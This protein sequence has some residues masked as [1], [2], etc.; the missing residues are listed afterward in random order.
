MKQKI[1]FIC[2]GQLGDLLILTTAL[3]GMK[4]AFPDSELSVM[5]V[6]R[7]FYFESETTPQKLINTNCEKGT[8]LVL[9][10]NP[11]VDKVFEVNRT[12]LRK[13]KGLARLQAEWRIIKYLQQ[14]KY[15]VVICTFPEDRFALWAYLTRA[16][17]RVG[18]KKQGLSW[19][20]NNKPDISKEENGVLNYYCDLTFA[21][22]GKCNSDK[23]EYYISEKSTKWAE[24]FLINKNI[25]KSEKIICIH[26]GASGNYKIWPPEKFAEVYDNLMSRD[27]YTALLCGTNFDDQVTTEIK[28][29]IKTKLIS[30]DFSDSIDRFAA[31]LK[32]SS[33]CISN[34]SGP[35]HLAVAVGTPAISIMSRMKH[36]AW[37]IYN[38]EKNI[39]LQAENQCDSCPDNDCREIIPD[40]ENFG[41]KCIRAIGV[42]EVISHVTKVLQNN[43]TSKS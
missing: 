34:D 26:P 12:V 7:R 16:K 28:N 17:I 14:G 19:L 30:V 29:H 42:D 23:T 4:N 36:K 35:R 43:I 38:E 24:E 13:F 32:K 2:E 22:G 37:K 18:Q 41:A 20:L 1:L 31:I 21:A 33:L 39:I 27:N 6:Q 3:R 9:I 11:F 40:R 5:I 8:S 10:N 15:D 25:N